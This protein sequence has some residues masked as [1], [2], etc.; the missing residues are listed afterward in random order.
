M[1]LDIIYADT[2]RM[3][4]EDLIFISPSSLAPRNFNS[5]QQISVKRRV[6]FTETINYLLC[7]DINRRDWFVIQKSNRKYCIKNMHRTR[8]F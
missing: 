7:L 3:K 1:F 8:I 4:S 2:Y 6:T 5:I